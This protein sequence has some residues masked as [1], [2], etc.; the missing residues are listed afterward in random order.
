MGFGRIGRN[1]FRIVHKREDI[2][3][4]AI[5]DIADPQ[6][7]AYLLR[8]DTVH[9]RFPEPISVKGDSMYV[10]GRQIKM[11][12]RREPGEVPWGELGVAIAI[13]AT[14]QYRFRAQLARHLEAGA[15]K[16]ILTVPPRDAID[17]TIVMGVND[18]TLT[19]DHRIVSNASCTANAVA[20]IVKILNDAFGIDK[21]MLTT[22]HAYTN[23]Q[24]LADVPHT[25][26]RRSRAAA[27]NII[28][29]TTHSPRV[30]MTML[31]E[32]AG[33]LDGMAMNVPVRD[34]S[35]ADLVTLMS[36]PL[37][38]EEIN[39]VVK[40][41]AASRFRSIIEYTEEPIVSSDV[42]GNPHSGVFDALSTQV[43]GG[44]LVKTLT[45][46]DNGWGYANRVVEL[47]GRL[48]ELS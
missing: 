30:I 28:P 14:G 7:L 42:I 16:V 18:H 10:R 12:T 6:A 15:K 41:A 29:T 47:I 4:A 36:R 5:A 1:I 24:R 23:D 45:W 44:N 34:G 8:F 31:P 25:E 11:L 48:T 46:Y 39:E 20:P 3:I 21:G 27:E 9:G 13:E 19:R 32:L 22:V 35:I 17:A 37:V 40:S 38:V 26:L 2:E 43:V 33:K